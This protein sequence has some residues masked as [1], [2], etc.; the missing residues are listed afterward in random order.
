MIFLSF[1]KS[2]LHFLCWKYGNIQYFCYRIASR[3]AAG[4]N[5]EGPSQNIS[6]RNVGV[7]GGI[8]QKVLPKDC[9]IIN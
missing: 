5:L 3:E 6:P 7:D 8:T 4:S 9:F 1:Q 2:H